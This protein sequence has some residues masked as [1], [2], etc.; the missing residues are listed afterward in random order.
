MGFGRH[1]T[2]SRTNR[3]MRRNEPAGKLVVRGPARRR[4]SR[5]SALRSATGGAMDAMLIAFA[6][7]VG[8]AAFAVRVLHWWLRG[9]GWSYQP[10]SRIGQIV[11]V[12]CLTG[13]LA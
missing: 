13:F 11:Q 3:P 7:I 12:V 6:S 1:P 9:G 2:Q 5:R 10:V 4:L 8:L